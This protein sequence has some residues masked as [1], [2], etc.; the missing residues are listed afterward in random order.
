MRI[1]PASKVSG[2]KHRLVSRRFSCLGRKPKG[3]IRYGVIDKCAKPFHSHFVV[4]AK[5][6]FIVG[7]HETSSQTAVLVL[8]QCLEHR[9]SETFAALGIRDANRA[10][11]IAIG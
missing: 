7:L 3:N 9:A 5:R 2:V 8:L 11:E 10:I 1:G 4:R 6:H